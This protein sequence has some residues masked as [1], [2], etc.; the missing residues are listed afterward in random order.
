MDDTTSANPTVFFSMKLIGHVPKVKWT[1][2]Q[3]SNL[4]I[5]TGAATMVPRNSLLEPRKTEKG[6]TSVNSFFFS[7]SPRTLGEDLGLFFNWVETTNELG[8]CFFLGGD[9][10]VFW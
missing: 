4:G 2:D 10:V 6:W 5:D 9:G 3:L 1:L 8:V 7:F